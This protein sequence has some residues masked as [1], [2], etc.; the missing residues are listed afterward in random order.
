VHWLNVYNSMILSDDRMDWMLALEA[1][2][3]KGLGIMFPLSFILH[4]L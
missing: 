4:V 3:G 2:Q 1:R